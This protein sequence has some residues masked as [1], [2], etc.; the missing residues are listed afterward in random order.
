MSSTPI[1]NV[2]WHVDERDQLGSQW[3]DQLG[4]NDATQG[5]G[6]KQPSSTTIGSLAAL[7]FDNIDDTMPFT[8][9]DF[10]GEFS[11]AIAV[12]RGST[13]GSDVPLGHDGSNYLQLQSGDYIRMRIAGSHFN[14]GIPSVVPASVLSIII[15]TRDA[16][17]GVRVYLNGTES[18]SGVQT[19]TGTWSASEIGSSIGSLLYD[20]KIGEIIL[21]DEKLSAAEVLVQHAALNIKWS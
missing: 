20:G 15:V 2:V 9:I 14:F 21:W 1:G 4:T 19:L 6:A 10:A 16:T 17:D 13:A 5:D 11:I 7:E 18:T 12:E 8:Q 3:D